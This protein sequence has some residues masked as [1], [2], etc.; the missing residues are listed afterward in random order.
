MFTPSRDEARLFF[1]NTWIR[2]KKGAKLNKIKQITLSILLTHP[3][4]ESLL[5]RPERGINKEWY[6]ENGLENPF[7]HLGLHLAISEQISIDQPNKIKSV[8][9]QLRTV[10][11]DEH[12]TQ[13][14]C[15]ET[16]SEIIWQAQHNH[17]PLDNI[18]YLSLLQKRCL[19][20]NNRSCV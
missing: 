16:L 4:Y 9:N 15:M 17:S 19:V 20:S 11:G 8:Y 12:Q 6:P 5:S 13:H 10:M 18:T 7:L 14:V 1:C 2:N 3:E